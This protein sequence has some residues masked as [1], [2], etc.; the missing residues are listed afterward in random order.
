MNWATP[1]RG[2]AWGLAGLRLA[3]LC[4]PKSLSRSFPVAP[5]AG[6][7]IT[8][9]ASV[10]RRPLSPEHVLPWAP[11]AGRARGLPAPVCMPSTSCTL[12]PPRRPPWLPPAPRPEDQ[13]QRGP[14]LCQQSC[15]ARQRA[16]ISVSRTCRRIS[17]NFWLGRNGLLTPEGAFR[18]P[19][20]Q[21]SGLS[22]L[23]GG[24]TL[25]KL[26]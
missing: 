18:E 26:M 11:E 12:Q 8:S 13:L 24:R 23:S 5:E 14:V 10:A 25:G 2:E 3:V 21:P 15:L 4:V 19:S 22:G 16:F 7:E 1:G 17:R 6:G 9:S 20:L